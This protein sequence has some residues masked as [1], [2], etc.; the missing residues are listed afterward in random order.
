VDLQRGTCRRCA[1]SRAF[2]QPKRRVCLLTPGERAPCHSA[3][4]QHSR[5]KQD[6]WGIHDGVQKQGRTSQ[7]G[8]RGGRGCTR[9]SVLFSLDTARHRRTALDDTRCPTDPAPEGSFIAETSFSRAPV[10]SRLPHLS[11]HRVAGQPA[12]GARSRR[13]Q[14]ARDDPDD[15]SDSGSTIEDAEEDEA[16]RVQKEKLRRRN[17]GLDKEP[18]EGLSAELQEALMTEDLLSVLMVRAWSS[19]RRDSR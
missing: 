14:D 9:R 11:P 18:L 2:E 12:Q 17:L 19:N 16:T 4:E 15:I 5:C 7:R 6:D 8:R 10:N 1:S 13:T 3:P